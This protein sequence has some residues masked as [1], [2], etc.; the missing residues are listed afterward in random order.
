MRLFYYLIQLSVDGKLQQD[1]SFALMGLTFVS[2]TLTGAFAGAMLKTMTGDTD[3][4]A[5]Q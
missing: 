5:K 4:K 2:N 1:N 3:G